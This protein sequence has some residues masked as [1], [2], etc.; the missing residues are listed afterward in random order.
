MQ[1]S[2]IE[3]HFV[4]YM[5]S[6]LVWKVALHLEVMSF[7]LEGFLNYGRGGSGELVFSTFALA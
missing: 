5:G 6:S 2:F 1:I 4:V 3:V 7:Y